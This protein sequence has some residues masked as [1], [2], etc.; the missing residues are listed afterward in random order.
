MHKYVPNGG[1]E[2][3]PAVYNDIF[4][5]GVV[6]RGLMLEEMSDTPSLS[7]KILVVIDFFYATLTIRLIQ[8]IMQVQFILFAICLIVVYILSLTY[9]FTCLR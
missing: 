8:I 4:Q 9:H 6:S 3:Q 1:L 5:L 7:K 2:A